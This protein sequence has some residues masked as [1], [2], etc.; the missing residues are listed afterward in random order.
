MLDPDREPVKEREDLE[1]PERPPVSASPPAEE[2]PSEVRFVRMG[3][4]FYGALL[5]VAFLWRTVYAGESLL[6]EDRINVIQ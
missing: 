1:G 5:A 2:P 3:L 4:V 6:G